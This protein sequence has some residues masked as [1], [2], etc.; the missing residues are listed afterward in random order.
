MERKTGRCGDHVVMGIAA[1]GSHAAELGAAASSLGVCGEWWVPAQRVPAS[2]SAGPGSSFLFP[3][4]WTFS[5]C[6]VG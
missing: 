6:S 3:A 4:L 5:S 1:P 2:P